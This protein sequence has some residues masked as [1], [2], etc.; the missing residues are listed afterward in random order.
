MRV[1]SREPASTQAEVWPGSV[2]M[3]SGGMARLPA[4]LGK[5]RWVQKLL[6]LMAIRRAG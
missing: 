4:G 1:S 6:C 2:A 3:R 5:R